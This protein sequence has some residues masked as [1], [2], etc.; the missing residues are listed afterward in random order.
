[1]LVKVPYTVI[2]QSMPGIVTLY[3]DKPIIANDPVTLKKS[4]SIQNWS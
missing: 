1:M 4:F 2:V 3:I